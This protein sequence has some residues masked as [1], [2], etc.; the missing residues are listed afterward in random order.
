MKHINRF[1]IV[2]KPKQP[3]VD[4]INTALPGSK[5][6]DVQELQQDCTAYLVSEDIDTGAVQGW[7]QNCWQELFEY[8]LW[9]WCRDESLWPAGRRYKQ[10]LEW[11]EIEMHSEVIDLFP[12]EPL[13]HDT[14]FR[15]EG[16]S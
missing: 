5:P 7:L 10:F 1:V 14:D 12:H 13:L 11:F 16:L 4:W 3:C 9:G 6:V 8:E 15:P 2:I